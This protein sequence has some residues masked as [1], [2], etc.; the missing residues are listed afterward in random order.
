MQKL[1]ATGEWGWVI[2]DSL[3][4]EIPGLVLSM[5]GRGGVG[6]AGSRAYGIPGLVPVH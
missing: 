3:A 4:W 6:V 5:V 2:V 1:L